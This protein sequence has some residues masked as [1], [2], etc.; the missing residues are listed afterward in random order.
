[1]YFLD[2]PFHYK[3]FKI[4]KN[5]KKNTSTC[6]VK[7][8]FFFFYEMIKQICNKLYKKKLHKLW[9][10][11]LQVLFCSLTKNYFEL[12]NFTFFFINIQNQLGIVLTFLNWVFMFDNESKFLLIEIY[13]FSS[14]FYILK[15]LHLD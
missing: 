9:K 8:N 12:F 4:E 13:L 11:N 5:K 7:V 1:M 6:R 2:V 3:R 14:A 10:K 15:D